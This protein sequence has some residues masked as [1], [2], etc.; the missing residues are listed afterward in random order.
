MWQT[1][2]ST[3][4]TKPIVISAWLDADRSINS[5]IIVITEREREREKETLTNMF[6]SERLASQQFRKIGMNRLR[7]GGCTICKQAEK[8]SFNADDDSY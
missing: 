2:W 6:S 7:S 8:H 5:S 3:A 4:A 1:E